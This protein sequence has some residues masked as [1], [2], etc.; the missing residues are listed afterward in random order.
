MVE[1][2]FLELSYIIILTAILAGVAKLLKQPLIIAYIA[3]G[4]LVSPQVFD[5]VKSH[6]S[7][8]TFSQLGVAFLLFMVG[9]NL[10]PKAVKD[11]GKVSMITGIG[12]VVFTSLIGFVLARFFGFSVVEAIYIAVALTFSSTIVIMKL[13]SDKKDLESLYGRISIGFLI[14]QDIV[15]I[16]ILIVISSMSSGEPAVELVIE[17]LLKGI[18]LIASIYG[19]SRFII[20]PVTNRI[21]S[22]QEYLIL[23]SIAWCFAW[24]TISL[25]LGFSIEIG[26]LLAGIS[27][28][29]TPYRYNISNKIKPLRDFFLLMF[30]VF[31]GGQMEFAD[32]GSQIV[33][34]LVFSVFI[35][36][37]NPLI[38]MVLM[39]ILGYS[40]RT[41]FLAGL[42]VAQISEFSLLLIALG[43]K[44]GHLSSEILSLVTIVG[45]ITISGSTYFIIYGKKIFHKISRFLDV[46]EKKGEKVDARKFHSSAVFD[47]ILIGYEHLGKN[48]LRKFRKMK[49]SVLVIDYNPEIIARLITQKIDCLFADVEDPDVFFDLEL[50]HTKMVISSLKSHDINIELINKVRKINP[51]CIIIV[52]GDERDPSLNLYAQGATYVITTDF[53]GSAHAMDMIEKHGFDSK[54][55]SREKVKHLRKLQQQG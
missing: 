38:V 22:Q 39:G 53:L 15:A 25:L 49:N 3:T 47:V 7:I 26:A 43:I 2:V 40:K 44:V 13:L 4:I 32:F 23:F 52:L 42:T 18:V 17:A 10:S 55:F 45:L 8:A 36:I 33:P 9:L 31:L 35:L 14:V 11:V 6:D 27:L 37:G 34:I 48:I 29:L 12:Q 1:S 20:R 50:K 41:S 30:F 54:S 16:L 24:A 28:S 5:L 21:A 51:K 46:F 19:A